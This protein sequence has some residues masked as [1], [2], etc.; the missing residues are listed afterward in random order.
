[1]NRR[2][3]I[4][5]LSSLAASKWADEGWS[6]PEEW[7]PIGNGAYPL[8][9]ISGSEL[10]LFADGSIGQ[11][12]IEPYDI[13]ETTV[14][15]HYTSEYVRLGVDAE[16]DEISAGGGFDLTSDEAR[17]L[18]VALFRAAEEMDRRPSRTEETDG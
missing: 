8:D 2:E 7:G 18:A 10:V 5:A 15:V 3:Y 16:G 4:A 1:M 11:W 12:T 13:D 17:N 6:E 9:G 14:E